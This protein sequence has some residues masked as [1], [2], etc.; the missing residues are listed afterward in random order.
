MSLVVQF[1]EV[2]GEPVEAVVGAVFAAVDDHAAVPFDVVDAMLNEGHVGAGRWW[3]RA[4]R[5]P[6]REQWFT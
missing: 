4:R 3:P 2:V 1:R 6:G 5:W